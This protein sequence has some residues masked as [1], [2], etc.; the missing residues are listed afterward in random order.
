LGGG[1]EKWKR[2]EI[3]FIWYLHIRKQNNAIEMFSNVI[4]I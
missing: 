4:D 3:L 1:A 2:I